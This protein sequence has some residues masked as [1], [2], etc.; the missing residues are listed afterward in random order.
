MN[1]YH[2]QV[3]EP[4]VDGLDPVAPARLEVTRRDFFK[5][6]GGGVMVLF[7]VPA[8]L[9]QEGGVRGRGGRGGGGAAPAEISVWIHIGEDGTVTVFTGKTEV[10]QNIRTSLTQAVAEELR[11]PISSIKMVMA[12]T[13]LVPYDMGTFGSQTTPLMASQ[14]HRVAAA[15]RGVLLDMAAE[16]FKV[17]KASL[18]IAD[19]KI[20]Q[21]NANRNQA[22][23]FGQ[24][25]KGRKFTKTVDNSTPVTPASEW[26]I[27]GTSVPKVDGREFVTGRHKYSS[28]MKLPGMLFGKVLRGPAWRTRMLSADTKTAEAM[29]GVK[30]VRDGS[31]IGVV[32]PDSLQAEYAVNAITAQWSDPPADQPTHRTIFEYLRNNVTAGGGRGGVGGRGGRGAPPAPA[33]AGQETP[34]AEGAAADHTLKQ[35]Y[36]VAYI[37]HTPLEPRAALADWKEDKLTVWTGTQR[38]FGVRTEL[39]QALGIPEASIRVIVPDTGSGYGGKHTGEAAVEA[40]RLSRGAGKPVKL[41]WT[42]EEEFTWA[43]FRPAAVI[44]VASGVRN[45]GTITSWEFYNYNSGSP[46]I[47]SPYRVPN[48]VAVSRSTATP[49]AQTSYRCLAATGNNFAREVHMDELARLLKM[50]PLEFRL[51]NLGDSPTDNCLRAVLEAA[52]KAFGWGTVK[53]SGGRGFGIACGTEKS[54]FL[55]TCAEVL[56]D[57]ASGTVKVVRAVTAFDC[58]AVV[59]PNHLKNQIEGAMVMGLGGALFEEIEFEKAMITNPHLADYRVPRFADIPKIEIVLL[60]H[61]DLPSAGAGESP[62]IGIAPAV[63]NAIFDATGIRLRSMPMIPDGLKG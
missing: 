15:A 54:G 46:G 28:D 19:G 27:A 24:L 20:F 3:L 62:I 31:F 51:K 25:T 44:D 39:A 13:D 1:S 18:T 37:A 10:G 48:P 63:G 38:P 35:T 33:A 21:T 8:A 50:D 12:D 7:L 56:A 43:F 4:E 26:K 40:A 6:L 53:A 60:D 59:N 32:A 41:V 23:S 5:T 14:L 2:T 47:N 9:A 34:A 17:D 29:E 49:L 52:A 58:G 45:D 42:R 30:V 57:T 22:V 11:A 16:Y 55:A 36:T 61:K